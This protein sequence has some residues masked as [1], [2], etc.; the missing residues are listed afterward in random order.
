MVSRRLPF[1]K[2]FKCLRSDGQLKIKGN[3]INVQIDLTKTTSILPRRADNLAAVKMIKV[4]LKRKSCFKQH[5]LYQNVRPS[6]V[7]AALQDLIKKPLYKDAEIDRVWLAHV[8]ETTK[9][10]ENSSD[11][12]SEGTDDIRC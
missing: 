4:K 11:L 1:M 10:M 2:I 6:L 5:Y 3:V 12:E 8:T 9:S 7:V